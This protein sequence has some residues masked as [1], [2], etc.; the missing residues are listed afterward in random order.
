MPTLTEDGRRLNGRGGGW[1]T[2]TRRLAVY[3]RDE[4]RCAYCDADLRYAHPRVVTLDHLQ[5][6]CKQGKHHESN[7]VTA[8]LTCNSRR[9]SLPWRLFASPEA[10]ERIRRLRRRKLNQKL[11]SALI[12]GKTGGKTKDQET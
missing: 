4:F 9:Q 8:C 3:L 2:K 11:A 12:T 10:Q 1:I 7:L 5:P 6:R